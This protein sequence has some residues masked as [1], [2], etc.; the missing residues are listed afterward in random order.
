MRKAL[1]VLEAAIKARLLARIV[2][3]LD[4]L[5]APSSL[6]QTFSSDATTPGEASVAVALDSVAN[7]DALTV[8]PILATPRGAT[9]ERCSGGC[10]GEVGAS[11]L[12][13]DA[14][15]RDPVHG[16]DDRE[17]RAYLGQRREMMLDVSPAVG[18]RTITA[19]ASY[20][21]KQG[22]YEARLTDPPQI[23]TL[24]LSVRLSMSRRCPGQS[25]VPPS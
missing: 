22:K 12:S 7:P 18:N 16:R 23:R 24:A 21:L 25:S 9:H 8:G 20:G 6:A 15:L 3:T 10:A 14:A 13:T 17:I 19:M 1:S 2:A 11:K 5:S 4:A